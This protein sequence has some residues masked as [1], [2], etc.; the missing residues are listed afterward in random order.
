MNPDKK[1]V[2]LSLEEPPSELKDCFTD[3]LIMDCQ[4]FATIVL[5]HL[6]TTLG[7]VAEEDY[8]NGLQCLL[9]FLK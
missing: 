9:Q 1:V 4:V 7:L 3:I 6:G 8:K 5:Q 2:Y